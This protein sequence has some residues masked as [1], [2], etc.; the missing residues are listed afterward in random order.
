[1][2]T[3][4]RLFLA[5]ALFTSLAAGCAFDPADPDD[6]EASLEEIEAT[7][8]LVI[9]RRDV[10][11][12]SEAMEVNLTA[13]ETGGLYEVETHFCKAAGSGSECTTMLCQNL[14][15]GEDHGCQ[16]TCGYSC[17]GTPDECLGQG[18]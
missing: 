15:V 18:C 1:M 11:P 4:T 6:Q 17:Q 16:V 5:L 7:T 3:R 13:A 12:G 10:P 2:P 14:K 8:G 9:R